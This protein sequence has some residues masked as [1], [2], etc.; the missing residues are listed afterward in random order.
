[1][2][3][4]SEGKSLVRDRRIVFDERPLPL[5]ELA[6]PV[7]EH[8][9]DVAVNLTP[10]RRLRLA[11]E[12]TNVNG[13]RRTETIDLVYLPPVP[14]EQPKPPPSRFF[15]VSIGS[16]QFADPLLSPLKYAE[17]DAKALAEFLADH[18][19]STD[20]TKTVVQKRA[21]LAGAAASTDSVKKELNQLDELLKEKKL[22]PG[23]VVAVVVD[24][25]V[26]ESKDGL[27][28]AAADTTPNGHPSVPAVSTREISDLLGQLTDYGCRVVMFVDGVHKLQPPLSNE[29]KPWIRELFLEKRVIT[30]VASE[31]KPSGADDREQHGFFAMGI[32]QAFQGAGPADPAQKNNQRTAP[33]TLDQFD[34]AVRDAVSK[35][36]A[37]D[38]DAFCYIPLEVPE[39]TLFAQ[40]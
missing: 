39:R 8:S 18:L 20:G 13:G 14:V 37:R 16:D 9:E 15:V 32:L 26:F 21:V 30:F 27:A 17:K 4:A 29:I 23:D 10:N 3:I 31:D 33:Y 5:A 11:I 22:R 38:Q 6:N 1:L 40:P 35:L 19:L 24:S 25:H 12:A 28:V 7:A 2:K 36:S 34:R